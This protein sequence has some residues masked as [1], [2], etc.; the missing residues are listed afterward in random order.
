MILLAADENL[1]ADVP[2]FKYMDRVLEEWKNTG[3]CTPQ[4]V[5]ERQELSRQARAQMKSNV[6][7]ESKGKANYETAR[8]DLD[9]LVE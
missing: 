5:R 8:R 2:G 6:K 9:F 1:S 3:V 7:N 4:Q